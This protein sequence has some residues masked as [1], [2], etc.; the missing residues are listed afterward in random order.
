MGLQ[1]AR[2]SQ[3]G[4]DQHRPAQSQSRLTVP[5]VT[6]AAV[7]APRA[8][9]DSSWKAFSRLLFSRS[10]ATSSA[11]STSDVEAPTES[12]GCLLNFNA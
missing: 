4:C 7:T 3:E 8:R 10:T 12:V 1:T 2:T 11:S 5:T 9:V 6:S